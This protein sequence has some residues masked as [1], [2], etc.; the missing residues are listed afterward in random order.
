MGLGHCAGIPAGAKTEE[1]TGEVSTGV[2]LG[3][4]RFHGAPARGAIDDVVD[5]LAFEQDGLAGELT[6]PL[7][8]ILCDRPGRAG[9][10]FD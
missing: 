7:E 9:G 2:E 6:H 3:E 1:T 10:D 4:R 8:L 5:G